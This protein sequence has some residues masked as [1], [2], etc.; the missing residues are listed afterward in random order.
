MRY[1]DKVWFVTETEGEYDPDLGE[2]GPAV[3]KKVFKRANVT[4]LG[5]DRSVKLF[6]DVTEGKKVIRL[7][8]PYT[9]PWDY[10]I[11]DGKTY[12]ITTHRDT[13]LRAGFIV[14]EAMRDG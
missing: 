11:F 2:Y 10:V 14:Q 1:S 12:D 3:L 5:T 9:E 6:G 8:R 7:L 13:R 4:D